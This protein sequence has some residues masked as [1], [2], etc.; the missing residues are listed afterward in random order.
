[1]ME[2]P[3][4]LVRRRKAACAALCIAIIGLLTWMDFRSGDELTVSLFYLVPIGLATWFI[5]RWAGLSLALVSAGL[6][7]VA[8][9]N[10]AS[11]PYRPELFY[12]ANGSELGFTLALALTLSALRNALDR[13]KALARLDSLT[14]V[15]NQRG[16]Y[17]VAEREL[18]R[19]RRHALPLT[20][21]YM[22]LDEFKSVN[23]RFG[24]QTG[25]RLL[26]IVADTLRGRLRTTDLVARLGGDEFALLLPETSLSAAR[27]PL[28]TLHRDLLD[29]MRKHAWPVT[30]SIGAVS[31]PTP[32]GSVDQM[33]READ[34]L[35]YTVKNGGKNR[36]TLLEGTR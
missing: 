32:P 20:F 35:M 8:D 19:A 25:D 7:L 28:D 10:R 22:D 29:A 34:A 5:G 17:E 1:M 36:L 3:Q 27:E 16:F 6:W 31:F 24:H 23:D 9:L 26:R 12:W 4:P 13:E 21:V 11:G 18:A 14:S 15:A 2:A 30:F 33:I